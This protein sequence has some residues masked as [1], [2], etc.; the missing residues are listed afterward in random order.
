MFIKSNLDIE[1]GS[2][3]ELS[4]ITEFENLYNGRL[5][6]VLVDC[7]DELVPIVRT[8][9]VYNKPV[10][11]FNSLVY[12][13]ISKIQ[14]KFKDIGINDNIDMEFNNA[15]IEIY[16][17]NY[18]KMRYHTDQSLDLNPDSYICLFS[19]Y[20]NDSNNPDD[21]RILKVKNK[22]TK[23]LSEALL[24]NNSVVLFSVADNHDHLHK[25][26]LESN[27]STNKWLGITFRLS[28]TFIRFVEN[29]PILNHNNEILR[30]GND[31]EKG[32]YLKHK[33]AENSNTGYC[34]PEINYTL[35]ASDCLIPINLY[36]N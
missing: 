18:R 16:D 25:I 15:L 1:P 12:K 3:K 2:F 26:V 34:Y 17:S 13:I 28:K 22:E 8:T 33:G 24:D 31:E 35:S 4:G 10:L 9:T 23:E 21:T 30:I 6:S 29:V 36:K 27:K 11:Q 20:E 7:Q 32:C 14:E 19:C 5:G